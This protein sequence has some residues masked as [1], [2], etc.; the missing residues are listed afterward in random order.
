[1]NLLFVNCRLKF[2]D[3]QESWISRDVGYP[4]GVCPALDSVIVISK[5]INIMNY[6]EY[7]AFNLTNCI[8]AFCWKAPGRCLRL[9]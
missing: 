6:R 2:E 4:A 5:A 1:M 7:T 8:E 9:S 3:L